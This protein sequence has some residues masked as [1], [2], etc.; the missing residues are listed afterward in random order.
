MDKFFQAAFGGSFLNHQ[1]LAAAATPVF[2][3][4]L[5]DGT[6]RLSDSFDCEHGHFFYGGR[7]LK[8]HESYGVLSAEEIITHS[9]N[10]GAAKIGI[11]EARS[12]IAGRM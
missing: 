10:I 8:D 5:N 12:R 3:G 4:A 9:S 11:Q 1:W 7:T 2:A 6:I